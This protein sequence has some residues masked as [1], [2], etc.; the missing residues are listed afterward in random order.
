MNP[1]TV[2]FP[3]GLAVVSL[4]LLLNCGVDWIHNKFRTK[5]QKKSFDLGYKYAEWSLLNGTETLESLSNRVQ[6]A[7]DFNKYTEFDAGIKT[8]VL[9][10]GIRATL[11]GSQQ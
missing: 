9:R 6:T 2:L 11:F 1:L 10:Y 5:Y 8:F 3:A 7:E 4:A